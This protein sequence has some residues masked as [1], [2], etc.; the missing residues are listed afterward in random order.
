MESGRGSATTRFDSNPIIYFKISSSLVVIVSISDWRCVNSECCPARNSR[1]EPYWVR[2]S[3]IKSKTESERDTSVSRTFSLLERS[4]GLPKSTEG[5][6]VISIIVLKI[7]RVSS[8][9][10][11]KIFK[12]G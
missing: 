11:I 3:R 6:S 10:F 2:R 7:L 8:Y 4:R 5:D 12:A 9:K 1:T